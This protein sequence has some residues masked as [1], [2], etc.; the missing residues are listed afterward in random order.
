MSSWLVAEVTGKDL[1][2]A[3]KVICFNNNL[4]ESLMPLEKI[5]ICYDIVFMNLSYYLVIL[6]F[7][8]LQLTLYINLIL[9]FHESFK[10]IL[11]IHLPTSQ[12]YLHFPTL[13]A[14]STYSLNPNQSTQNPPPPSQATDSE[15]QWVASSTGLKPS[16]VRC[17]QKEGVWTER[18]EANKYKMFLGKKK[19]EIFNNE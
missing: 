18:K 17:W 10:F 13:L 5:I 12:P 11:I 4:K 7:Y 15:F 16:L 8:I 19:D 2:Q 3:K 6:I 14:L 9:I 1:C